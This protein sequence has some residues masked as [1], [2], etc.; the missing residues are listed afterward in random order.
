MTGHSNRATTIQSALMIGTACLSFL[1]GGILFCVSIGAGIA[2]EGYAEGVDRTSRIDQTWLVLSLV[3]VT[4]SIFLFWIGLYRLANVTDDS[5][6]P[7]SLT[8]ES[9]PS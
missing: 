2:N 7:I 6:K 3:F 1:I 4:I 5:R 9:T 8:R